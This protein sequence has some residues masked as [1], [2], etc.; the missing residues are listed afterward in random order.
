MPVM[1][2][3]QRAAL[4]RDLALQMWLI[5]HQNELV[6]AL[7]VVLAFLGLSLILAAHITERTRVQATKK[8]QAILINQASFITVVTQLELDP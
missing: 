8:Q 6:N 4:S 2:F 1:W 3:D 5:L 7:L